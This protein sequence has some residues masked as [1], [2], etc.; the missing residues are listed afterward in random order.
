MESTKLFFFFSAQA[1]LEL[2][3]PLPQSF[4][5][6]DYRCATIAGL[7]EAFLRW[8]IAEKFVCR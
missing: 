1:G 6:W 3:D 7:K 8:E 2:T 4:E 5:C